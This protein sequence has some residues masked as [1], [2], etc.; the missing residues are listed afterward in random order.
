LTVGERSGSPRAGTKSGQRSGDAARIGVR[1]LL[2]LVIGVSA[3]V[4][5]GLLGF[6]QAARWAESERLASDRQ[7]LAAARATAAQLSIAM[8]AYVHA[9]ESFSAQIGGA[10][11]FDRTSLGLAMTAHVQHHPEFF[12]AYVADAAG[13]SLLHLGANGPLELTESGVDYSDRDYYRKVIATRSPAISSVH[14]GRVTGLLTVQ[15][16]APIFDAAGTLLGITC[17]SVDLRAI[18]EQAKES[19]HTMAEGRVLVIDG[20]GRRIVDSSAKERLQPEDVSRLSLFSELGSNEAEPRVGLDD[21][22]REVRGFAVALQPPVADWRVLAL[23]P[24]ATV[25]AQ[26]RQL[27][28]Q[29]IALVLGLGLIALAVAAALAA[30][31]AGPVRALARS[32]QAV[33]RG[34]LDSLPEVPHNAPKEMA[35]LTR[36][37]RTMIERLASHSRE[38]ERQVKARTAELSRANEEVSGALAK[39]REHEQ[40]RNADLDQA[41]LFQ[42][43]LLPSLPSRSDLTLAAYYAPLEEV[44]GDIYDVLELGSGRVR[45]FLADATGHGVQASMRTLILKTAYDR[46]KTRCARPERLLEELNEHLV[47]EFPDGDLHCSACCVDLTIE[48]GRM[49]LT[50]ANAG[51]PPLYV[52]SATTAARELYV[53]GPLLG[54]DAVRWPAPLELHLGRGE[55]L[56]VAS[57][58][59]IEQQSAARQRFDGRLAQLQVSERCNA[60]LALEMLLA[61][62]EGFLE[63][64]PLKDDLTVLVAAP[65]A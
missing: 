51:G 26:A 45:I 4:P 46:L 36:S 23:T 2:F 30:W 54:V 19:V 15:V 25:D 53:D 64:Q 55:L 18:T 43:K 49:F 29:T 21:R 39:I 13:R 59:L 14:I 65:S 6:D 34:D 40:S 1:T 47:R 60:Q 16:A 62:L 44:G 50:Y 9:A 12:G 28:R 61:E 56:V 22:A 11:Q 31:L 48:Q 57:D 8:L 5:V 3:I 27:V 17:S 33:T 7:A 58:G 42:E 41:R 63:G 37:V 32:A 20:E 10:G 35:L 38:L 52:L 24:K